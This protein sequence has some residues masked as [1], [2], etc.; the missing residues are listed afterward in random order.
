KRADMRPGGRK[1][2]F[3]VGLN[4]HVCGLGLMALSNHLYLSLELRFGPFYAQGWIF[5]G[6]NHAV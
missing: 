4:P 6:E 3:G 1:T 5:Y 2:E